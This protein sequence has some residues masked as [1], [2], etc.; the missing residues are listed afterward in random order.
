MKGKLVFD[1]PEENYEFELANKGMKVYHE[2]D[3]FLESF[4][5]QLKHGY[6]EENYS[7]DQLGDYIVKELSEIVSIIDE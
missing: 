2:L 7:V 5:K 6:I 3:T 1:L 4:K